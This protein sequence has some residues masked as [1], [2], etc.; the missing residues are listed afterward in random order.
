[1][2]DRA[3]FEA[4]LRELPAGPY[5]GNRWGIC[6]MRHACEHVAPGVFGADW[7]VSLGS[8][9]CEVAAR[10]LG[11]SHTEIWEYTEQYDRETRD[12]MGETTNPA[13]KRLAAALAVWDRVFGE[14]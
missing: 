9:A 2:I 5:L 13:P 4:A 6:P 11:C 3:T 7:G 1:M 12:N 10:I 8:G 14:G